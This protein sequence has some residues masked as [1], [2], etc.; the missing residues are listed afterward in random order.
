[1]VW[2]SQALCQ[3]LNKADVFVRMAVL[4]VA[5]YQWLCCIV[6]GRSEVEHTSSKQT[7]LKAEGVY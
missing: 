3:V 5:V 2:R 1:M 6:L 7:E 4:V